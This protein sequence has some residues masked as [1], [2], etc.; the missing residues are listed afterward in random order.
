MWIWSSG[1][2]A[3]S[4]LRACNPSNT[5]FKQP[6]VLFFSRIDL[7]GSSAATEQTDD[8]LGRFDLG[9]KNQ[10]SRACFVDIL[11]P[12]QLLSRLSVSQ[13]AARINSAHANVCV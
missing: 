7:Q 8:R 1:F 11:M 3:L 6:M 10:I 2:V 4:E 13:T 9:L 5:Y 12:P